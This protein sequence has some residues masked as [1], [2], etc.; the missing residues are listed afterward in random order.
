VIRG[1]SPGRGLGIILFITVSRPAL[2]HEADH[3]LSSNGR[4]KKAWC[5]T[6]ISQQGQLYLY[7]FTLFTPQ[8]RLSVSKK[9]LS[10]FHSRDTA[11]SV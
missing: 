8:K 9:E 3:L 6:S 1:S 10:F 4:V 11:Q 5:Y 7:I 2:R